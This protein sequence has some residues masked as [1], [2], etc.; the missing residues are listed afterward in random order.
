MSAGWRPSLAERPGGSRRPTPRLLLTGLLAGLLLLPLRRSRRRRPARRSRRA[1]RGGPLR[2]VHLTDIH[3][4]EN[5][6]QRALLDEALDAIRRLDPDLVLCGGDLMT[7]PT[8]AGMAEVARSWRSSPCR[9]CSPPA[10]TTTATWSS[11]GAISRSGPG[12]RWTP[13]PS[14]W[15]SST[16][17]RP[18]S[19]PRTG[20]GARRGPAAMAGGGPPRCRRQ[21]GLR[22]D[23][24][25][26]APGPD[27]FDE[28]SDEFRRLAARYGVKAVFSGHGHYDKV[29][30]LATGKELRAFGRASRWSTPPPSARRACGGRGA[31]SG[32]SS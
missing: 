29:V 21:G 31:A 27:S 18:T 17:G 19:S 26:A 25:S 20:G 13:A 30:D 15:W 32:S 28:G 1:A 12:T 10:T 22:A 24:H 4:D 9:S 3:W 8:E 6:R 23:H 16:P 7:D 11:S 5:P 14:T 2:V